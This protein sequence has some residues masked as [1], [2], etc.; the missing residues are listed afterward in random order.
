MSRAINLSD[1]PT[2]PAADAG[3]AEWCGRVE[4]CPLYRPNLAADLSGK[5]QTVDTCH[6]LTDR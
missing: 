5:S 2:K 4:F 3:R 1:V 6:H